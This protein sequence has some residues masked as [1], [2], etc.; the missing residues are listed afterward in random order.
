MESAL[1]VTVPTLALF[2][3]PR[4]LNRHFYYNNCSLIARCIRSRLFPQG[5]GV[6]LLASRSYS[7][8]L[9]SL[10]AAPVPQ[11]L[12]RRLECVASSAAYFGAAGGGGVYGGGDGSGSGSGGGGGDG[13]EGT[14]DGD[15][16][17]K[18]GAGAVDEPS[19]L[20]P[21][22]IILDVGGMTCGGCAASVKR[23]LENQPQVS[24][25]SVNLTT[26]TAIVWPVSEAKVV[27]NW[28][29][30]LGEALAR[31]LTSCGFNSNLRD[32][33]RDN[34]F[35]V[36]ERKMDEKRSRL[37]ESGRELAVSWALCA[38][39]L[40]GH[41][42]HFLG[43]KA[44]WMHAFH[45]TGFHLS[46][47]LFTL[48]GPGRQLI[49]EGVKNLFKGAPNMNTLVGLG[50]LSSFAVSSL[51]V[52]IP[53]LGWR[54]FFEEPVML[55]AFVLLGRNLEQ[56][57]KIKAT[58]DMTG[59]LSSL[60]SQA[61]LMVDDSIV[62][63]PCS[64]LSVG[65]QIV[66]L[67][68]DRVPADGIVRAGR[69]TIDESSFTGEPMP[70]TK[71]P[72]S[73]V[74]AGSINLNGTLTIEVRRPGGETAMG[75]I[76]RLVEEA[77]SREAPVQ[78][79]A[80]K[81]AGHF[82]YGVM[83]LS[84][85]TFMFWNL[86]GARIIPASI[87]QGST[88]SLA[89]QLSCSVLVVA[90]PCALG[91]ATPTAMLV[92]T[93]LGATR[94]LLLRGGNILEKFSM[95]NVI[96]FDKTGTLTIGRP[97]VT[98]VVTPSGMDH[99]DSR[100][101]FNGSW[102]EDDVLKLAAAVES[103]TIHPVGK[104]IVEAAQAVKSPNIKV[105]DGTFVE[106]PG[107]GAVAVINDKTVS[108]GTLEWVQRHGVG[109]SLLLET[110]EE[111]R[112]K[113]VVYVGVNNKLAGLIYFEDQI[114]EDA[115]HVVDSLYRQGISVYMLS[116]DKR[117]TAEYVASIVGIP[118]DKVLSQVKPDEKRKFVSELQEN[119]NVVAMV[120]D[121]INDAAALASAHIGVAMGGGVGAASEVSSIVL[122]GNRLS[123]LL[124]ALALSQLTMKTVKQN[125]WWAFAY[126]IVGIP[127][128]AGTLLPLTGTMLTPSIA[129]AL[130]GLSSIGVV[131][132]SLLL[133][134]R[135]SLQQQQAYRSSLQ[136]PPPPPPYAAVDINNDLAM[137]HSKAKLKKPDSIT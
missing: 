134:F 107:S 119:Q 84:A 12:H 73:Q 135:F 75:D 108:V 91:L 54:A 1:S 94:G 123:Q 131:T 78:R 80:D 37:R 33:G 27:P 106:E 133:R 11:R 111:L 82:T 117:S 49:F 31:Q 110:D 22:I 115:R 129:G 25:A 124:D 23:I 88:V 48:L 114:R 99:S 97:V 21:D 74:A 47:S 28:Q 103:N 137:D 18:L 58:S 45:S 30:E 36:F 42:A 61:R 57:A 50:A 10:C 65:D 26:E 120:G 68:G 62:E 8:P 59:L 35:K 44:S 9:R 41:V 122:M 67:P 95:V 19:A 100:Q 52:L 121:G 130:M 55:I 7:S 63:V 109:D 24:S 6:T 2:S 66:V 72:G 14:G 53:K 60:P 132:N 81:V 34:F 71:E 32:S 85:A 86:F 136:P 90:C 101:H 43:A 40:I 38:V 125:L 96:I 126:N 118:K 89:L 79:L 51:A 77:Q 102:S 127:I 92:G 128:A 5:R 20:S 70:V 116:G 15:L 105:V 46:L 64:S 39:C 87:Y 3:I 16:K 69:S 98:K 17:A 104:A 113:S 4:A 29:K 83:A 112:N 13:G 76:V 56:R 93:S